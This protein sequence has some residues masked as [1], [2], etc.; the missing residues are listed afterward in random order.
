MSTEQTEGFKITYAT[1]AADSDALHAAFDEA[2]ERVRAQLGQTH[3]MAIG[4]ELCYAE[5]TFPNIS[6]ADTRVVLGHF[7]K[8]TREDVARAVASARAASPAWRKTPWQERVTLLRKAADLISQQRYDFSVIMVMEMGK[9]RIEALG[10]VEESADLIRYYCHQMEANGG[11][12]QTMGRLSEKEMNRD[13]LKPHGVWAVISPFNFPLALAAGPVGAALVTGNTV[14]FKPSSDAPWSGLKLYEVLDQAGLPRGAV[15]FVTG[16]GST[17]GAELVENDGV[18]GIT[19]TGSYEVGFNRV[20][21]Q[22]SRRWPKPCIVEM[23]GKNPAIVTEKADLDKAATGVMRSAFGMG[24]QKC[25][26]CSRVYVHRAV[27]NAFLERL[28][29]KTEAITIGD[30]LERDVFLGPLVHEHAYQKFQDAV[31]EARRDGQV[32]TG[33]HTLTEG[34]LAH[35][36]YVQP[37]IVDGLPSD[38]RLL[39]DELFVPILCVEAVDSLDEALQKANASQYG[40]TA[41]FYSEDEGEIEAFFDGIQ[42]GVVY[43]NRPSGATTGAWPGCQPFGGWKGSGSTGKNIGGHYTIQCYLRE[44]SQTIIT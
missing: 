42:A 28:I 4:G 27:K 18:D 38:H 9:S 43:V 3:P 5:E 35:G 16:S 12:Q 11:F 17:V 15:N 39:T 30:P 10:D 6:P 24:G 31:A 36:Y 8:G 20:Y 37:T 33:G 21:R 29:E 40:L 14:V 44:Q 34:D 2:I 25:S 23:G 13:V 1:M 26:A 7:Q 32:L 41:G 22:F 19:F